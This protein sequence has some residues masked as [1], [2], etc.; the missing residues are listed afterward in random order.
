MRLSLYIALCLLL[1]FFGCSD[2]KSESEVA[3]NQSQVEQKENPIS[4]V[5]VVTKTNE[6]KQVSNVSDRSK[7]NIVILAT[8][9]TIAG[10]TD[11]HI[12]TT[13]YTAGVVGVETLI[14]AVPE[15]KNLANIKGEQIA[16]IDSADMSNEIWLNL[17]KRLNE[18]LQDST[19]DGAVITHGTDTMEETALFLHLVL[20]SNK[21]VVIV[22]AMRP[23]TAMSADGAKNLYNG[24]SL[25]ADTRAK[26]KGVMV[27][28]NDRIQSA[29]YVTKTH[30]LNV[31][32]F[33]STNSGDM[34][35]IVDGEAFFYSL[36]N[37]PHT[38]T[39][40]FDVSNLDTLP[41]VDILY[42]YANDGSSI[43]AQAL[44]NHGTKGLVVAG[45][46]AGSIHKN[47]KETLRQLMQEGLIVVQSSRV[48]AGMVFASESD[49]ELGF[50]GSGDLNPQK[51]RVLLM[52]ALTQ[53]N[54]TKDIAR[55]FARY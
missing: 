47:H 38:I 22:G 4:N 48:N 20:K 1:G 5:D 55:I 50:I 7:P 32:A 45:S 27:V 6:Q 12:N 15:I 25:A 42:S 2:T 13:D 29:R 52:L 37:K 44:F 17:A 16:N 19:V 14:N 49:S 41:Q 18:L 11:S 9:G 30:T 33:S 35:Y 26:G 23:S 8:G 54:N 53:T 24:V 36:P 10:T 51:A 43:A 31:D 3:E 39:S 46:G 21:P 40:E 34:G 28:M